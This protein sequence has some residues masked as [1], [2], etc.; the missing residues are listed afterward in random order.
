MKANKLSVVS[1]MNKDIFMGDLEMNDR[2]DNEI[3]ADEYSLAHLPEDDDYG[4]NDG[5][6]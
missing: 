3:E 1:E 6:Q 4:E 5:D 2:I